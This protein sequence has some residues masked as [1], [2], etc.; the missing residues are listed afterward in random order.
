MR[1]LIKK[2]THTYIYN[3]SPHTHS[4]SDCIS[5]NHEANQ[6][7]PIILNASCLEGKLFFFFLVLIQEYEPAAKASVVGCIF[8]KWSW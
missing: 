7:C 1:Q 5:I 8:R 6:K 3:V 2:R 4:A